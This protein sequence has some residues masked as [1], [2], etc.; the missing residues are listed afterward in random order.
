MAIKIASFS[1]INVSSTGAG[2]LSLSSTAPASSGILDKPV[3]SIKVPGTVAGPVLLSSP[4]TLGASTTTSTSS[5]FAPAGP[6]GPAMGAFASAASAFDTVFNYTTS[7]YDTEITSSGFTSAYPVIIGHMPL[8]NLYSSG[9][10]TN[11]GVIYDIQGTIKSSSIAQANSIVD[12]YYAAKPASSSSLATIRDANLSKYNYLVTNIPYLVEYRESI[13]NATNLSSYSSTERTTL[14]LRELAAL[15]GIGITS[16]VEYDDSDVT[17]YGSSESPLTQVFTRRLLGPTTGDYSI[18]IQSDTTRQYQLLRAAIAQLSQGVRFDPESLSGASTKSPYLN[19]EYNKIAS[20]DG[21]LADNF[22]AGSAFPF[23]KSTLTLVGDTIANDYILTDSSLRSSA[24]VDTLKIQ[25]DIV[26]EGLLRKTPDGK[27][28][29]NGVFVE[30]Q[31]EIL[32]TD[33]YIQSNTPTDDSDRSDNLPIIGISNITDNL[34]SQFAIELAY[35][36]MEKTKAASGI[37][38]SI[39]PKGSTISATNTSSDAVRFIANTTNRSQIFLFDDALQQAS[40]SILPVTSVIQS[41]ANELQNLK[42]EMKVIKQGL[43]DLVDKNGH[44]FSNQCALT[45]LK[46]FYSNIATIFYGSVLGGSSTSQ[47]S[48]ARIALFVAAASDSK[49]AAKLF[50]MIDDKSILIRKAAARD[51]IK[52]ENGIDAFNAFIDLN[53]GPLVTASDVP[54]S[55]GSYWEPED[56]EW[57]KNEGITATTGAQETFKFELKGTLSDI[58]AD[59]FIDSGSFFVFNEIMNELKSLYPAIGDETSLA[60]QIKFAA[61]TTFLYLLKRMK[62]QVATTFSNDNDSKYNFSNDFT[63]QGII[64]WCPSDAAFISDSLISAI[65]ESDIN[66]ISF[67]QFKTTTGDFPTESQ[68]SYGSAG[69]F[70]PIRSIVKYSLQSYED[71]LALVS[72]QAS[73]I[74][75]QMN[76]IDNISSKTTAISAAYSANPDL[77]SQIISRYLT[78]ESVIEL[79]Y[80]SSRYQTFIPGTKISSI[81]TRSQNYRSIV[82]EAFKSL[83]PNSQDMKIAIIGIPYGHLERL[84]LSQTERSY[85]FGISANSDDVRTEDDNPTRIDY[86][87]SFISGSQAVLP[88]IS[89]PYCTLVPD[90]YDDF[91]SGE[92]VTSIRNENISYYKLTNDRLTLDIQTLG[93]STSNIKSVDFP[94]AIVQAALKSYVEEV[95]GLYPGFASMKTQTRNS[96]FPEEIYA[97]DALQLA[98]IP[99]QSSE[100]ALIYSR[101]KSTIMMHQDFITTRMIEEAESSPIFDKILYIPIMGESLPDIITQFYVKVSA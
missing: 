57:I 63:M 58:L 24:D 64:K 76:A 35:S 22:T 47:S 79:L 45:I 7:V 71:I 100:E 94:A 61:F 65:N 29:S 59:I 66:N 19:L 74:Q 54:P 2:K 10:E 67:D 72:F 85:Y 93:E 37:P 12:A 88:A 4:G 30:D 84:R 49:A 26:Y 69:F 95:Y 40:E 89:G 31:I 50:R 60:K 81:A 15:A 77:V 78:L 11:Y 83:I 28:F 70:S 32:N 44:L 62:I 73:V 17:T 36:I 43:Y 48:A 55:D 90:L 33:S 52:E 56:S 38:E 96:G 6:T 42:A 97:D 39:D 98:G 23:A 86:D 25:Y 51:T 92:I 75:S 16:L 82:T 14:E 8:N 101:L 18:G 9:K 91:S 53:A 21:F 5:P 41:S 68:I 27:L 34:V 1:D 20:I 13:V 99:Y 80:R 87:F 3:S 46:T